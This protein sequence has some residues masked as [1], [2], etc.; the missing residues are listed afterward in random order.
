MDTS[1]SDI[2]L[3]PGAWVDLVTD[4]PA[5]AGQQVEL[6]CH[7]PGGGSILLVWGG[8]LPA[9]RS[10]GYRLS[11]GAFETGASDHIWVRS[12]AGNGGAAPSLSVTLTSAVGGGTGS[13]GA[14][15]LADGA[16]VTLGAKADAAATSATGAWSVVSLL[17]GAW[18]KLAAISG[19]LPASLGAKA[20]VASL[21]ITPASDLANL[22][23]GGSPITGQAMPA[24][25]LGLTG[26]MS[27]IYKA[28]AAPLVAGT[29]HIGGVSVD[30]VADATVT[31]GSVTSATVVVS[32][33][34]AGFAGGSFQITSIGTGNTVA[35]EQS[36]DNV[37]WQQ[38]IIQPNFYSPPSASAAALGIY[39]YVTSAAYVRA[40]VSTYGSGTVS[41][42]LA[43]KRAPAV[44]TGVSL[45]PSSQTV[46]T[47]YLAGTLPAF[48]SNPMVILG[49]S[50]AN[51]GN[52]NTTTGYTENSTALT[53]NQIQNGASHAFNST[54]GSQYS[55]FNAQSQ[56]DQAGTLYIEVSYDSGAN[57]IPLSSMAAA[58][59]TRSD[60]SVFY[61]ATARVAL[62]GAINT[63]TVYRASY[64]NGAT[65]NTVFRLTSSLTAN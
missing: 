43:Q 32:A 36:N 61:T 53:A 48:T 39:P 33:S 57:F 16:S 50:T 31:S 8:A 45:A 62:T 28:T 7:A 4:H 38:L 59:I 47:V 13:G 30:D 18:A 65:A 10:Q 20:G 54:L 3:P 29:A 35:F 34:T 63:S 58:S 51:V 11:D 22:E 21:S 52:V 46:G 42:A 40:R 19:Q 5:L 41:V 15:T 49:G 14:T 2:A 60:G 24:G 1:L 56:A 6:Q 17:K 44:T 64:K 55:Y 12:I 9:A 25:G 26:W 37:N 23:P 27:A